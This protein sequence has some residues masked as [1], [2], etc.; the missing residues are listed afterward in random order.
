V[1]YERL[2]KQDYNPGSG[3]GIFLYINTKWKKIHY[4]AI[5]Q[6]TRCGDSGIKLDGY[7]TL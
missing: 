2:E 7:E 5:R 1:K 4:E 6:Y 3:I